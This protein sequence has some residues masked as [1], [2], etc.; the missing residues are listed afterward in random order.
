MRTLELVRY[1]TTAQATH[2]LL[3]LDG[4]FFCYT[5]EDPWHANKIDGETRIHPGLYRIELRPEGGMHGRYSA[6]VSG[7]KGMLWL[8]DTPEFKWVYIHIGNRPAHT[9]GCILVGDQPGTDNNVLMSTQAYER[10][11]AEVVDAAMVG[12]LQIRIRE[13]G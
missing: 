5:L 10:L 6:R 7:H 4:E 13:M 8:R 3:N 9:E 12:G 1:N 2:G 11:Y